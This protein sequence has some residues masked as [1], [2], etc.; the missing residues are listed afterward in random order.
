MFISRT[1]LIS[2]GILLPA[3]ISL[4]VPS[5]ATAGE[6]SAEDA[7]LGHL[8]SPT[9][10]AVQEALHAKGYYSGT[11]DGNFGPKSRQA[12]IKFRA[13]RHITRPGRGALRLDAPLV[14]ALFGI[15]DLAVD[16]WE[17]QQCL[18]QKLGKIPPDPTSGCDGPASEH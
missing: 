11:I 15:H 17:A 16:G 7:V 8:G 6:Q 1:L 2:T 5:P 14:L 9:H 4:V 13:A 12:L 18:L 10:R 3:S